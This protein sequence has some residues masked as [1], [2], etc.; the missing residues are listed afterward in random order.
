MDALERR[1]LIRGVATFVGVAVTGSTIVWLGGRSDAGSATPTSS[2]TPSSSASAPAPTPEAWLAWVPG[3]L[4]SGFGDLVS[5]VPDVTAFATATADIAW[6]T[7]SLDAN[8]D[9]V[10]E[11]EAPMMIPM[12][13]TGVDPTFATFLP[14][15]ERQLVENLDP[16]QGI[17][18]ESEAN[19]RG[20]GTGSTLLFRGGQQVDVVG[21]LPDALMGAY[22][23]LVP[24]E[25]GQKL[26]VTTERYV[27]FHVKQNASVTAADLIPSLRDLLPVTTPYPAVEVRAPGDTAFLRANDRVMPPLFLKE[28]FGE[29]KARP[30]TAD[31]GHIVIDPRWVQDHIQ[32]ATL[33]VLGSVTCDA[34]ILPL[35]KRAIHAIVADGTS[36]AI[37]DVGPC[38]DPVS[39][40]DDP[41]GPLTPADWGVSIQLDPSSNPPGEQPTMPK[42]IVQQ[43]YKV[44][45]GW[46]GNDAYPQGA[47]FRYR[48]VSAAR[49]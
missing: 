8:G 2:A 19:L 46:G 36:S 31:P 42:P 5:T 23:V 16:G 1:A 4:P 34:D 21:T 6:M 47:V 27:L 44:G 13:V 17:L 22:E 18:S 15:P 26:G 48:T 12:D 20:L 7:A 37:T 41:S 10:D 38:F 11:P 39:A 45:F 33:P 32:S 29:F 40:P 25:T 43:M 24:R 28:T 3:G 49:D 30:D 35:L 9:G 14:E